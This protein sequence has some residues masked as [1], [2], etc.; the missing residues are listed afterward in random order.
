MHWLSIEQ[1][2]I[3]KITVLLNI[4]LLLEACS[5]ISVCNLIS[6][7]V[8]TELMSFLNHPQDLTIQVCQ[9]LSSLL[10]SLVS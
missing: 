5:T 4:P 9:V 3:F 10:V 1:Q 7:Y 2:I 8:T 6:E